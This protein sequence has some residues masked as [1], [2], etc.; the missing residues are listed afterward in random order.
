ML[1]ECRRNLENCDDK[2]KVEMIVRIKI[3]KQDA[4]SVDVLAPWIVNL[5]TNY[6]DYCRKLNG[7][8]F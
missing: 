5:Q 4:H 2:L 7:L 8:K 3:A 1:L 6:H